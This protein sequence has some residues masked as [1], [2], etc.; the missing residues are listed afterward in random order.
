M[1]H[2]LKTAVLHHKGLEHL[3]VF[4]SGGEG[5]FWNQSPADIERQLQLSFGRVRSYTQ[6]FNC[7]GV[8]TP[9][10]PL[11]K[12]QLYIQRSHYY[13]VHLTLIWCYISIIFQYKKKNKRIFCFNCCSENL[14]FIMKTL[15]SFTLTPSPK[16][17]QRRLTREEVSVLLE[18]KDCARRSLCS[19]FSYQALL[20]HLPH[21]ITSEY[22]FQYE[23]SCVFTRVIN[24]ARLCQQLEYIPRRSHL[25]H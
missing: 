15:L 19:I 1:A 12:G 4:I 5:S 17:G 13:V 7:M 21:P 9:S 22:I 14:N 16:L 3:R 11:F 18:V 25:H 24:E 23:D 8:G 10:L 6:I 2:Q 20:F